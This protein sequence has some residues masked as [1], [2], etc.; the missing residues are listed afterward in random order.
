MADR[1]EYLRQLDEQLAA[2]TQWA[3]DLELKARTSAQE[4]RQDLQNTY[5][6]RALQVTQLIGQGREQMEKVGTATED[7]WRDMAVSAEQAWGTLLSAAAELA[8]QIQQT[9]VDA[10]PAAKAKSSARRPR[11][12]TV[13][14]RRPS[15]PAPKRKVSRRKPARKKATRRKARSVAKTKSVARKSAKP[16]SRRGRKAPRKTSRAV[17]KARRTPRR[18]ARKK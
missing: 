4:M 3:K 5:E 6:H 2:W 15:K 9:V 14:A 1:S 7:A 16:A 12:K 10:P 11:R 18:S 17:T 8:G 13:A